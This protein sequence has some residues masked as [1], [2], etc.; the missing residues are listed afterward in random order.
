MR[1]LLLPAL[2]LLAVPALAQTDRDV[3]VEDDDVIIEESDG[4][5]IRIIRRS[6][7]PGADGREVRVRVERDGPRVIVRRDGDGEEIDE[8]V[9]ELD[10]D[11][12]RRILERIERS[13]EMPFGGVFR[14]MIGG[15]SASPETRARMRELDMR[16]RALAREA[17]DAE[18]ADRTRLEREL[19]T[20]LGEL[21]DVRG[22]ARA[23]RAE[24]LREQAAEM[25][26]E[27]DAMDAATAE[28]AARRAALIEARRAELLGAPTVD[29]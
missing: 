24:A 3:E 8:N 12:P 17:R 27:A 4:D 16:A 20:V 2:A 25:R 7:E 14:E 21:F 19:D 11:G 26:A 15:P 22:Q 29:F 5:G 10:L 28:R 23:E 6:G 9:F 1:L 18:G 13:G